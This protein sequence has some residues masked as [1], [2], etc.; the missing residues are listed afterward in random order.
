MGKKGHIF[1][2]EVHLINIK[3]R[4]ENKSLLGKHHYI[5]A[6]VKFH[7]WLLKI[8]GQRF[9]EKQDVGRVSKYLP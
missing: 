1:L 6:T 9:A 8:S 3:G 7:Q 4:G 5:N 2:I